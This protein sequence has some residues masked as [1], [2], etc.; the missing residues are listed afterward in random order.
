MKKPL[1]SNSI[2]Q[3]ASSALLSGARRMNWQAVVSRAVL[4]KPA[5]RY[6]GKGPCSVKLRTRNPELAVAGGRCGCRAAGVLDR[7]VL[8]AGA[9]PPSKLS[10]GGVPPFPGCL[11]KMGRFSQGPAR[12]VRGE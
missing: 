9:T 4:S 10:R 11:A 7:W 5:R 3:T 6:V 1:F 12:G 8:Y 2:R